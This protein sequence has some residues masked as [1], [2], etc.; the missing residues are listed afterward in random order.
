MYWKLLKNGQKGNKGVRWANA[1]DWMDQSRE[2]PQ[3][4]YIKTTLNINLMLITK[5]RIENRYSVGVLGRMD[6]W[7]RLRW[8]YMVDGLHIPI[9]NRIK[10]HPA[11]ALSG[12]GVKW[13]DNGG[14]VTKVSLIRIVTM[15][16]PWIMNRS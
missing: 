10:K 11:I 14:D 3:W 6:E 15:N 4:A 13:R 1:R 9:W 8:W 16:P 2:H 7:R 5:Y 12:W